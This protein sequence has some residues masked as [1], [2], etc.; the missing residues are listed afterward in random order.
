MAENEKR[1]VTSENDGT[2]TRSLKSQPLP[3]NLSFLNKINQT[4]NSGNSSKNQGT[5]SSF[6]QSKSDSKDKK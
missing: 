6:I 5:T 2:V 1:F 3:D 4:S